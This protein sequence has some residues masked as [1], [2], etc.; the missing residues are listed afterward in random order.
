MLLIKL[1]PFKTT[2]FLFI[3]KNVKIL[4][5]FLIYVKYLPNMTLVL[6]VDLPFVKV[7]RQKLKCKHLLNKIKK[8]LN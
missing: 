6:N 8:I 4:N 7:M 3:F 5:D 1:F 2:N